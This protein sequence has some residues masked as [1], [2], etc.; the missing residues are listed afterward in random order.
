[1]YEIIA[2]N[3]DYKLMKVIHTY[4]WFKVYLLRNK[5]LKSRLLSKNWLTKNNLRKTL[6]LHLTA[7]DA[8]NTANSQSMIN[9]LEIEDECP[10]GEDKIFNNDFKTS[11]HVSS[12]CRS[13]WR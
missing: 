4:Y 13:D 8:S 7:H 3:E 2:R 9:E 6:N 10:Y 1:M 11:N 12:I 5:I